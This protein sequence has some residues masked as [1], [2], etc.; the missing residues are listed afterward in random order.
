MWWGGG[1][2]ENFRLF[3]PN[4][5]ISTETILVLIMMDLV[6]KMSFNNE[7]QFCRQVSLLDSCAR[8]G[9]VR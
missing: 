5:R 9:T 4:A 8:G 3:L 6:D 2:G 7:L 1:G